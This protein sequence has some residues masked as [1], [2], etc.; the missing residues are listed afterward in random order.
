MIDAWLTRHTNVRRVIDRLQSHFAAGAVTP[1]DLIL[2]MKKWAD[3][4]PP[5]RGVLKDLRD[6]AQLRLDLGPSVFSGKKP[7]Q[8]PRKNG[9]RPPV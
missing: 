2:L 7:R 6:F 9:K 3:T 4:L 5:R 1:E 8:R